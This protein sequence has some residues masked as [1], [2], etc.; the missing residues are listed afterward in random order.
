MSAISGYDYGRAKAA[1][2]PG[3]LEEL[4]ALEETLGWTPQDADALK[5]AAAVLAKASG[6]Q[7]AT[8]SPPLM[9]SRTFR[10]A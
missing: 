1:D 9:T 4:R 10:S 7:G 6:N 8:I 5:L 2:S 3:S